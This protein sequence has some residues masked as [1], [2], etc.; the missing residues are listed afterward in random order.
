MRNRISNFFFHILFL[1]LP[2]QTI[3]SGSATSSQLVRQTCRRAASSNP[4]LDYDFC[5]ASLQAD[6]RSSSTDLRGLGIITTNLAEANVTETEKKIDGLQAEASDSYDKNRL[7]DC[8][9]MYSFAFSELKDAEVAFYLERYSDANIFLSAALDYSVNC[10]DSWQ[11]EVGHASPLTAENYNLQQLCR[12]GL[13][14]TNFFS[15]DFMVIQFIR[16]L[17]LPSLFSSPE[18]PARGAR[19]FLHLDSAMP[20]GKGRDPSIVAGGYLRE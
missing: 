8:K 5:V 16:V 20:Q 4:Y 3:S 6:R 17:S 11:E 10:E 9:E 19:S 14:I 18:A 1:L 7:E 2:H 15:P 12:I 13:A